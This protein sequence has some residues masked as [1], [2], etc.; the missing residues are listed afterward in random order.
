MAEISRRVARA[1]P[2]ILTSVLVI[3]GLAQLAASGVT[4]SPLVRAVLTVTPIGATCLWC[5]AVFVVAKNSRS[6]TPPPAWAWIFATPPIIAF[7]A[8]AAGWSMNNS[9]TA[10]AFLAVFF[11]ALWLAAQALENA[12]TANG[13]A[14][15]GR[16]VV[17]LF[18]MFLSIAGVW[19]LSA[20]IRRV[21]AKRSQPEDNVAPRP[22]S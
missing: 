4:I 18:L 3:G 10:M 16:I 6:N 21:E 22:R 14:P 12:D 8:A 7:V 17:T 19:A 9:P 1:H 2:A 20:K 15:V 13:Y 5:W 11:F